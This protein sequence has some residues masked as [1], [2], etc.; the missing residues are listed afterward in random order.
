MNDQELAQ[1]RETAAGLLELLTK[2][3][4][5]F[6]I[7]TGKNRLPKA[8]LDDYRSKGVK[9]C[10]RCAKV[11]L[12]ADF[13][14]NSTERYGLASRC[15]D[16]SKRACAKNYADN[17]ERYKDYRARNREAIS[18]YKHGHYAT[19]EFY[20]LRTQLNDGYHRAVRAG[21]QATYVTAEEL[22]L[23]WDAIGVS[24]LRCY[25]TGAELTIQNRSIDHVVPISSGGSH[26]VANLMPA[27]AT[28]NNQKSKNS[29]DDHYGKVISND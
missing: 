2:E 20:R 21:N 28:A 4:N 18:E 6:M 17:P 22:L 16:C 9:R 19:N 10:P 14:Q 23:F 26:T 13:N 12:I 8:M 5:D 29:Y 25:I 1:Q 15:K 3:A 24:P 11:K 7:T 27:T